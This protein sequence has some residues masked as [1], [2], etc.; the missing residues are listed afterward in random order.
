M[1]PLT[2]DQQT[3]ITAGTQIANTGIN[4]MAQSN[5]NKKTQRWNEKIMG[6]QRQQSL[7]DWTMQNKYN[8]PQAQMQ[9][10][11]DAG[12]NPNLIYG[13]VDNSSSVVRSTDAKSWN[14][15]AIR[16]ELDA[17]PVMDTYYNAQVKEQ[18][19]NNLKEQNNLIKAQQDHLAAQDANLLAST[20]M[21]NFNMGQKSRLA[22]TQFQVAQSN[23]EFIKNRIQTEI[24]KSYLQT[25]DIKLR[26]AQTKSTLSRYETN[27]AMRQPTLKAAAEKILQIR[28]QTANTIEQKRLIQNQA[29]R[30]R[31]DYRLNLFEERMRKTGGST[32]DPYWIR[33]LSNYL[34]EDSPAAMGQKFDRFFNK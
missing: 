21:T 4:A 30:V 29:D 16:T 25:E 12:L 22:E 14:P 28:A 5:L 8:S 15:Q 3:L 10:L 34:L 32:K 26:Q 9:R 11:K 19:I 7:E 20:N 24:G 2:P 23:L 18:T 6:I 13:T 31:Q 1:P 33:Q 17:A 27:E